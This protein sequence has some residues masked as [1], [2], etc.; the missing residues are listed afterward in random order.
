MSYNSNNM[1]NFSSGNP[2]A[3]KARAG[4]ITDF[5]NFMAQP[6]S[7]SSSV[8]SYLEKAKAGPQGELISDISFYGGGKKKKPMLTRK[9]INV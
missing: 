3:Q 4:M 5:T 7:S 1:K 8:A 9:N 2:K 6:T